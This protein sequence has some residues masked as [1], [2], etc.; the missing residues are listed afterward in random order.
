LGGIYCEVPGVHGTAAGFSNGGVQGYWRKDS[1]ELFY[2]GLDGAMMS[3][4]VK[5]APSLETGIPQTLFPTQI[6]VSPTADQ[7][8]V[9]GDGQRFLL[10]ESMQTE[11]K[12]LTVILNWQALLKN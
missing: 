5:L 6:R 7:F 9:K 10:M 2:L 3:V 12:P 4:A 8:A 11:T 1:K